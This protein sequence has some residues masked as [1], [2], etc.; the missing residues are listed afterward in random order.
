[1]DLKNKPIIG[2]FLGRNVIRKLLN[3]NKYSTSYKRYLGLYR[4]SEKTK[5][6]LYFFCSK[7][8]DFKQKKIMGTIFNKSK[9]IWVRK[10]VPF[11]DILYD[12]ATSG[13]MDMYIRHVFSRMGIKSINAISNFNKWDMYQKFSK[14]TELLQY[15]PETVQLKK[16]NDLELMLKKHNMVY[17]KPAYG[18]RGKRV[19]SVERIPNKGYRY[20]YFNHKPIIG[21]YKELKG[22]YRFIKSLYKNDSIVIVQ[23]AI[24]LLKLENRLIDIRGE[25][26][27]RQDGNLEI[28]G[29]M[30]RRGRE[31]SPITIHSDVYPYDE[32]FINNMGISNDEVSELK[33]NIESVLIKI[34]QKVEAYYGAFGELG[35]DI[36]IDENKHIWLIE[37]N[38]R[39]AKVSLSKAYKKSY[40][41]VFINPVQYAKYLPKG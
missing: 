4:V 29:I 32:F 23:Q 2:V 24:H 22:V 5:V 33:K 21:L 30:V 41:D 35:I 37:C 7:N 20:R 25:L 28:M 17:I 18:N 6:A 14:D 16:M 39:T 9:G 34:F 27:R 36:G 31:G 10:W 3:Q 8:V 1:M 15:L 13:N 38:G 11:P 26:Q 19:L 40:E 12:R